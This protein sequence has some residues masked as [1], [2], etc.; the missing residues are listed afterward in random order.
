MSC[1]DSTGADPAYSQQTQ[2]AARANC[3]LQ[4]YAQGHKPQ[5]GCASLQLAYRTS[6]KS[7][8]WSTCWACR[9]ARFHHVGTVASTRGANR[10]RSVI[11][12][13]HRASVS[14]GTDNPG[15]ARLMWAHGGYLPWTSQCCYHSKRLVYMVAHPVCTRPWPGGAIRCGAAGPKEPSSRSLR[16]AGRMSA[17]THALGHSCPFA[18]LANCLRSAA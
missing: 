11:R 12:L 6:L 1:R 4:S 15:Q 5:P 8:S 9:H 17:R 18:G 7:N 14:E 16:C 3:M 13:C 2:H 10:S